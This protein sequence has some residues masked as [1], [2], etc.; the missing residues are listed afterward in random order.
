M[1]GVLAT[2]G[3]EKYAWI[4]PQ[5]QGWPPRSKK[6]LA[7]EMLTEAVG[8]EADNKRCILGSKLHR[9]SEI[10]ATLLKSNDL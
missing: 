5:A 10:S 1:A 3:Y 2:Q 8:T 4:E 7:E 9:K 6:R